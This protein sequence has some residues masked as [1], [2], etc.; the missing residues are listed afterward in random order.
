MP[1]IIVISLF[2]LSIGVQNKV[3]AKSPN[4]DVTIDVVGFQ[5]QWTVGYGCP[6]S[7]ATETDR[8]AH[9][10][11]RVLH[12]GPGQRRAR[13]STCRSARRSTSGSTPR[14]SST[15]STCPSSCTRRTSSRAAS[16][17]STSSSS[18]RARTA[19]S[20][21]SCAA[22][23][24]PR[25]SSRL[26]AEDRAAYDAWYAGQVEAANASPTPGPSGS[27][28]APPAGS[29]GRGQRLER[30]GLR[31]DDPDRTGRDAADDPLRQQ[32]PERGAQRLHQGAPTRTARTSSGCRSPTPGRR[33]D[34]VTP[35]LAA[36]TL[37]LL[38]QRPRQHDR[39]PDGPVGGAMATTTLSPRAATY[40]HADRWST[41]G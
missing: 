37:H 15:P 25:C 20:A 8:P 13:T 6:A 31:P 30:D 41:S 36:G 4:P 29:V 26:T 34:Y 11:L 21:P 18:S 17:A 24:M 5:W 10:R 27:G 23:R 3:E 28:G 38:L 39:H 14:T 7:Y 2:F 12:H 35:P 9:R 19:A 16:T 32:R 22:C 33:V 40:S 1:A